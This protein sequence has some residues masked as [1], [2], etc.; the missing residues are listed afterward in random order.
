MRR[1]SII[2]DFCKGAVHD[3]LGNNC[4]HMAAAIAFYAFFSLFPLILAA[5]SIFGMVMDDDVLAARA[6]EAI[7]DAVPV[8]Q[9]FIA[10]TISGVVKAWP[11]TGA[12]ATLGLLWGAMSVFSAIRK[13]INAAWSIKRPRSFLRERLIDFTLMVGIGL[14]FIL[15]ISSTAL[16]KVARELSLAI[17]GPTL[18]NTDL[19]MSLLVEAIPPVLTF[20]TFMALY[21]YLPNV[22]TSWKDV[23]PGA[24]LATICFETL[25]NLFVWYIGNFPIYNLVYGSLGTVVALLAWAYFSAVILVFGAVV[26]YQLYKLRILRSRPL[27]TD[28]Y[29]S[30]LDLR[31]LQP[32]PPKKDE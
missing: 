14:L 23:W 15:S 24:L 32:M 16:L 31:R 8:S 18:F 3:F 30:P 10:D 6:S 1:K 26:S 27:R 17:G 25:K 20:A 19:F 7:G 5:V 21:K 13:G 29:A 12:V 9:E 28:L 11:Y 4:P 22:R 2:L